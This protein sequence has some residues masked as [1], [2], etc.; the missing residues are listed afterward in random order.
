MNSHPQSVLLAEKE[1]GLQTTQ[2]YAGRALQTVC[3]RL[4]TAP[5][6]CVQW[7]G[8]LRQQRKP[9]VRRL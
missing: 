5:V 8:V 9:E 1:H 2:S 4:A 7:V 3:F 6:R